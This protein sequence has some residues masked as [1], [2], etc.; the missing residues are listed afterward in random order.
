MAE[1]AEPKKQY[2]FPASLGA[3]VDRLQ[4]LDSK[5]D[6]LMA[7]VKEIESEY[8]ALENLL[9]SE[10]PKDDLEGAT[11]KVAQVKIE[12]KTVPNAKDWDAVYSYIKKTGA[13]DLLQKRLS[14]S[15]CNERWA[16]KRAIPGVEPFVRISLKLTKL[17]KR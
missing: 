3:R 8:S 1:A 7:Q 17:K 12:R 2:K 14:S 16:A 6:G 9:L 10:I 11:G 13:F 5:R 4:Y 15:A